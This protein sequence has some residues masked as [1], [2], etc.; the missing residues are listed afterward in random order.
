LVYL[1]LRLLHLTLR[2]VALPRL[3]LPGFLLRHLT[4]M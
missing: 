4:R 1:T 3:Q 2:L